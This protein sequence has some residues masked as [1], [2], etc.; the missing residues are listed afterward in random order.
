MR[1]EFFVRLL[2]CC[3]HNNVLAKVHW[4]PV[5]R[6]IDFGWKW[7]HFRRKCDFGWKSKKNLDE[8]LKE[9]GWKSLPKEL[10]GQNFPKFAFGW[11][12]WHFHRKSNVHPKVVCSRDRAWLENF[13]ETLSHL[14]HVSLAVNLFYERWVRFTN[15]F[16]NLNFSSSEIAVIT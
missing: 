1:R 14:Q 5:S 3:G 7:Q 12:S 16:S 15:R 2:F 6:T 10:A 4:S 8:S 11:K 9:F 13:A